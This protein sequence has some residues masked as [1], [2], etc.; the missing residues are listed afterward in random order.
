MSNY[1]NIVTEEY[2]ISFMGLKKLFPNVSFSKEPNEFGDYRRVKDGPLSTFD[3]RTQYV[4]EGAPYL[5]DEN[6]VRSW[7]VSDYTE[8]FI[9][10]VKNDSTYQEANR[11]R[12][13]RNNRLAATDWA[14]LPDVHTS[15]DML[16]YRQALREIPKQS[17]FPWEISWPELTNPT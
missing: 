3:G 12:G 9:T 6:Y 16:E 2:P 14:V 17:S 7:V 15:S 10:K 11:V 1:L 5:L 8:E 13:D 4:T